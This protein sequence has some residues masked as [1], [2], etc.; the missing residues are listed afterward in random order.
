M[1]NVLLWFSHNPITCFCNFRLQ[2]A[3]RTKLD[4]SRDAGS[5]H[6]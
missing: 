1:F 3:Y 5:I 4:T 6:V 2:N